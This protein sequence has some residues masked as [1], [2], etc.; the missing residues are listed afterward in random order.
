LRPEA[1][2]EIRIQ[3]LLDEVARAEEIEIT[4]EELD[5]EYDRIAQSTN[6]PVERVRQFFRDEER[7]NGVKSTLRRRRA[8]DIIVESAKIA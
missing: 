6:Q 7:V 1:E 8:M 2:R 3:L 4:S 5:K